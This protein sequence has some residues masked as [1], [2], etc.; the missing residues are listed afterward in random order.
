MLPG[1][2]VR[3][4]RLAGGYK[5]QV[6]ADVLDRMQPSETEAILAA[7]T[8]ALGHEGTLLGLSSYRR[9]SAFVQ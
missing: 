5:L 9:G 6:S 7:A 2:D 1:A 4:R 8:A 3:C